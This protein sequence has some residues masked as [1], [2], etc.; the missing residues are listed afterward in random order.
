MALAKQRKVEVF[1]ADVLVME[2]SDFEIEDGDEEID[3]LD[4]DDDPELQGHHSSN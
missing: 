2:S 4:G 3:L 1:D